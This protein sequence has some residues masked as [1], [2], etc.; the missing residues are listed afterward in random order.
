MRSLIVRA[1]VAY[2]VAFTALV[3]CANHD[4]R[5]A[6][7]PVDTI[8]QVCIEFH[9]TPGV[10]TLHPGDTARFAM[11]ACNVAADA[12][13][14][15]MNDTAIASVDSLSGLVRAKG[16]GLTSLIAV[17]KSEPTVSGA[18]IVNVVP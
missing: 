13:R 4:A 1:A 18:A 5:L 9:V 6:G 17:D 14:W 11:V 3:G 2:V 15:H 7:P 8:P 10:A 16:L 12:W